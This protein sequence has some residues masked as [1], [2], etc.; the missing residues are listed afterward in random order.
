MLI[1]FKIHV[2]PILG[3]FALP[4]HTVGLD[5]FLTSGAS[6]LPSSRFRKKAGLN[7]TFDLQKQLC[8]SAK[9]AH[10]TASFHG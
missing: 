3:N 1:F 6:Q 7:N 2:F 8:N 4:P 5:P 9:H 10:I